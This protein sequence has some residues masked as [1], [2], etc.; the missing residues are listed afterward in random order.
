[1]AC[2]LPTVQESACTSGI[3]KVRDEIQLLQIIAQLICDG[4]GG[5]GG[6]GDPDD[7]NAS[8]NF[9]LAA[10]TDEQTAYTLEIPANTLG[11]NGG[12]RVTSLW[13]MTNNA[14]A[15]TV[16]YYYGAFNFT[17]I[18]NANGG[19][20][21]TMS[22]FQNFGATNVQRGFNPTSSATYPGTSTAAILTGTVDST[23]AVNLIITG[24]KASAGDS[25]ILVG[26][27]VEVFRNN[28]TV[29]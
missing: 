11:E 25:M 15:K 22:R 5:G 6:G 3:G 21:E 2:D 24:Q 18:N 16:R 8:P 28:Q 4:A 10:N 7:I 26:V 27:L 23:A 20:A 13:S 9:T 14:N 17:S 19:S 29:A 12:I 1:M